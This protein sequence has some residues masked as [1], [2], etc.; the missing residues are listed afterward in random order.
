M[1]LPHS[2]VAVA[3]M[4]L[5]TGKGAELETQAHPIPKC[6]AVFEKKRLG[7]ILF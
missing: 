5:Y 2:L 6:F 4:H 3:K 1:F 7:S